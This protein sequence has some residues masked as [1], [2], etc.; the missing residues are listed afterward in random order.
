MQ[1]VLG[2]YHYDPNY[3]GLGIALDQWAEKVGSGIDREELRRM[4]DDLILI[5]VYNSCAIEGNQFSYNQVCDLLQTTRECGLLVTQVD[6][7]EVDNLHDALKFAY[8]SVLP[9]SNMLNEMTIKEIHNIAMSRLMPEGEREGAYRQ[10]NV[11][12]AGSSHIPPPYWRVSMEMHDLGTFL[13]RVSAGAY[14]N[15]GP[16]VLAAKVH[17]WFEQI[18]PFA[19]GNGRVGR[20][21]M[22]MVLLW[23]GYPPCTI[24]VWDRDEYIKALEFVSS[25]EGDIS[26]FIALM[27][28][29][30]NYML[31]WGEKLPRYKLLD[32]AEEEIDQEIKRG[33][34]I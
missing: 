19:D 32:E 10:C 6:A 11:R 14:S 33:M 4:V 15:E 17:V 34:G 29:S 12:I 3:Y 16:I 5:D 31:P 20:A 30:Y 21:L 24:R 8:Y 13:R 28:K 27:C 22:N 23:H 9:P 1:E 26:P 18:H 25:S 7:V 2:N